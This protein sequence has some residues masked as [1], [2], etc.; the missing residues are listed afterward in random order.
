MQSKASAIALTGLRLPYTLN[1]TDPSSYPAIRLMS[2]SCTPASRRSSMSVWR[3][4]WNVFL[5]SVMPRLVLLRPNHFEGAWP[6]LPR[7]AS[8]SGKR[9]SAPVAFTDSTCSR[10]KSIRAG[11]RGRIL[12]LLAF[13]RFWPSRLSSMRM[14]GMPWCTMSSSTQSENS[15]GSSIE[16][17][18]AS[19]RACKLHR[20]T[21]F[22]LRAVALPLSQYSAASVSP[23]PSE[24]AG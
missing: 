23:S 11:W 8:S 7:T 13:F 19:L 15:G 10:P 18:T 1:V 22:I 21:S 9:R 3:K 5:G 6:S 17:A 4:L 24:T 20:V 12:R 2:E 14:H 16:V